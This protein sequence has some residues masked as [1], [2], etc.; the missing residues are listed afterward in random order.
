MV[1][2]SPTSIS[3]AHA[4]GQQAEHR[5]T[6][7]NSKMIVAS[8]NNRTIVLSMFSLFKLSSVYNQPFVFH[9]NRRGA[10]NIS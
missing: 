5:M 10:Q 8:A 7:M 4:T 3:S 9:K 1:T 2:V 6:V